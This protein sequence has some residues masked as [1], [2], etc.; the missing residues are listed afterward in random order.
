MYKKKGVRKETS[1]IYF[2]NAP[3]DITKELAK[4]LKELQ[5]DYDLETEEVENAVNKNHFKKLVRKYFR[6]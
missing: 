4:T 5:N 3:K 2:E 1:I 6:G